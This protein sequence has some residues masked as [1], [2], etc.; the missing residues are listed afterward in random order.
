MIAFS[1]GPDSAALAAALAPLGA[2]RG[3]HL[4]LVH[5]DHGADARSPERAAGAGAMARA[6]GLE[7]RLSPIDVPRLRRRRESPEAAARRLRYTELEN[8][9]RELGATRILTAHHRDDQIE[10][11]LLK[12]LRGAAVE[13]LGGIAERRGPLLR[14]WLGVSRAA[15]EARLARER[16]APLRDPTNDNLSLP[17]N[18]VRRLLMP[19]LRGTEPGIEDALLS[20][21]GRAEALRARFGDRFLSRLRDDART[22]AS[23]EGSESEDSGAAPRDRQFGDP[24]AG[25]L[26]FESNGCVHDASNAP[27]AQAVAASVD[28]LTSLPE[29]LQLPALRWLLAERL[30]VGQLPSLRSLETFLSLVRGGRDAYLALPGSRQALVARR[31]DLALVEPKSP[32]VPFTYTFSLPGEVELPEL[33]LRLRIRRSPVEPWM[34]RGE[35]RRVGFVADAAEATVRSRRSGD[36][37]RPLGAPGSR[38]LKAVLI[39]RGV[40]AAARDRLPLLEI[41]GELAWIPGVTIGDGFALRGEAECWLA[42]LEPMASNTAD[43]VEPGERKTG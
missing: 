18:R 29:A 27:A 34:L 26:G 17:R 37:L 1:G 40:P 43:G 7:F 5:V 25:V 9:R 22:A 11:V 4:T 38:K 36:R 32:T 3:L 39:D 20:L 30:G 10:T 13:R 41:A 19:A 2:D 31:G 6:L 42:E 24:S 14:P 28:F 35:R 21:A 16:I 15:I 8:V 23:I 12:L 33:E